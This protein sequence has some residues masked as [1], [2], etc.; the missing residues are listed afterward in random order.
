MGEH[1]KI[2]TRHVS[3][4]QG[5]VTHRRALMRSNISTLS[6]TSPS[7]FDTTSDDLTIQGVFYTNNDGDIP[8]SFDGVPPTYFDDNI[9]DNIPIPSQATD[10]DGSNSD[11]IPIPFHCLWDATTDS[12]LFMPQLPINPEE[13]DDVYGYLF[14]DEQDN[15]F[16]IDIPGWCTSY[17]ISTCLHSM[18]NRFTGT[19][20][21]NSEK[22]PLIS[23][24]SLA[25]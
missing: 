22:W 15:D 8:D 21:S 18:L 16:G 12:S 14:A 1:V 3:R 24:V 25:I 19:H 7:C 17:R 11:G 23:Y 2:A 4:H 9:S 20:L 10:F 13:F 6:S 5:L